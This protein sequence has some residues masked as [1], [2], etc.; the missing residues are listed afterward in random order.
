MLAFSG[1]LAAPVCYRLSLFSL[2]KCSLEGRCFLSLWHVVNCSV[3]FAWVQHTLTSETLFCLQ[4]SVFKVIFGVCEITRR[5]RK[6][7]FVCI[8]LDVTF[9]AGWMRYRACRDL[10]LRNGARFKTF[11][12]L[13]KDIWWCKHRL[14]RYGKWPTSAVP[15][16]VCRERAWTE[17]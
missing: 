5:I 11:W 4:M 1:Q 9:S 10:R 12:C 7:V 17:N 3:I 13:Q 15:G 6:N 2:V 8:Y 14:T 16:S